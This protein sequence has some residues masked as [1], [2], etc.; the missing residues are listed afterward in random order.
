MSRS[1]EEILKEVHEV[2]TV[3]N[4]AADLIADCDKRIEELKQEMDQDPVSDGLRIV[5]D[6]VA[7]EFSDAGKAHNALAEA[8]DEDY[9]ACTRDGVYWMGG[10]DHAREPKGCKSRQRPDTTG[11]GGQA[12]DS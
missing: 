7:Y 10:G 5:L 8:A 11:D 4:R 12:G 2:Q 9:L 1:V 6:E 3:K